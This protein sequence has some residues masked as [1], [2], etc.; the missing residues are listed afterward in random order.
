MTTPSFTYRRL[1]LIVTG[2]VAAYKAAELA[3]LAGKNGADVTCVLTA[4]A[5]KF[6][7]PLLFSALTG[8]PAY[9]ELFDLKD[10]TEMGH[11][12]LS[13]EV[14]ALLVAP[15]TAD[16]I[17]KIAQGAADDLA[18][19]AVLA[20]DKPLFVAPAMN[21]QMYAKPSVQRNIAQITQDGARVMP[22]SVGDTACG[23]IGQGRMPEPQEILNWMAAQSL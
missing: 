9:T 21:P 13:R 4:S 1:L 20:S 19:S 11:I 6:V 17:R 3:R 8:N 23:E 7:T 5:C 14:D 16:F 22:A 15:A 12:R 18:S 2:G 10:E